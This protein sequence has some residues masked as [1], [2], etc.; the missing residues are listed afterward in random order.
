MASPIDHMTV[1]RYHRDGRPWESDRVVAP[2]WTDIETAIRRM[3][4]YCFPIVMLN[5]ERDDLEDEC[6]DIFNIVG[7]AGRWALFRIMGDWQYEDPTGSDEEARLWESDQGY[8]C[9]EKNIVSD[10]EK[11]LRITRA[12]YESGS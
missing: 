11:V 1:I 8:F 2:K 6:P 7:G 4:N 12:Y 3:D 5:P 9:K 10:V